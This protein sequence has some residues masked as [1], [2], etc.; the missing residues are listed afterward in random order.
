MWLAILSFLRG[1]Q[2][3]WVGST[4]RR[5]RFVATRNTLWAPLLDAH[6]P[7]LRGAEGAS[8]VYARRRGQLAPLVAGLGIHRHSRPLITSE[9]GA[10]CFNCHGGPAK[11]L[12]FSCR[13]AGKKL[14]MTRLTTREDQPVPEAE[15]WPYEEPP[16]TP[17]PP[18]LLQLYSQDVYD[19]EA[20]RA[21]L[22]FAF[23]AFCAVVWIVD[24]ADLAH[25]QQARQE[26]EKVLALPE[27]VSAKL[28]V[29]ANKQDLPTSQPT[30]PLADALALGNGRANHQWA[31]FPVSGVTGDG[32]AEA[33]E[34]L[35]VRLA[36]DI[37]A[38]H[39]S[40]PLPPSPAAETS[41]LWTWLWKPL[42][43]LVPRR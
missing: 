15:D 6:F 22:R 35:S 11:V 1:P 13:G 2:W 36:D 40:E 16:P 9:A 17:P 8:E 33:F 10:M 32:L 30:G 29:L 43:S 39:N 14:L 27:L 38:H 28:L 37:W 18:S 4:C 5:L 21:Q 23:V 31:I 34:W 26:M 20:L 3:V 7:A 25:I 41:T 12:V 24:S 42:K 19:S